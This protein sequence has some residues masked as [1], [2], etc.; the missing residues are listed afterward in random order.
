MS[1]KSPAGNLPAALLTSTSTRPK[2]CRAV[3]MS[4][5]TSLSTVTSQVTVATSGAPAVLAAAA[6]AVR[7]SAPRAA[8]SSRAPSPAKLSAQAMPMPWLAPVITTTFPASFR[9]MFAILLRV[10]VS[11]TG[12][13]IYTSDFRHRGRPDA[14]DVCLAF[15]ARRTS[16]VT[17]MCGPLAGLARL[18]RLRTRLG[19]WTIC[20]SFWTC[21]AAPAW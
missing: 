15:R 19:S 6:A 8:S 16:T 18:A 10:S 20:R 17:A 21:A 11:A 3:A 1:V 7:P 5:S 14:R 2:R 12:W 4:C 9:S 13:R